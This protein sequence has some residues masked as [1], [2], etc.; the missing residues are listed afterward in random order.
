MCA[1]AM[2]AAPRGAGVADVSLAI[3]VDALT[4]VLAEVPAAA[5]R[6]LAAAN[7]SAANA[8]TS[9]HRSTP[10]LGHKPAGPRPVVP[11]MSSAPLAPAPAAA[12]KPSEGALDAE[13]LSPNP[14]EA[15]MDP[16]AADRVAVL[17]APAP[18]P[19]LPDTSDDTPPAPEGD[20]LLEEEGVLTGI[21]ASSPNSTRC[22]ANRGSENEWSGTDASKSDSIS[23]ASVTDR[24]TSTQGQPFSDHDSWSRDHT[25]KSHATLTRTLIL[26]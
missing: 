12:G 14:V 11:E 9:S 21:S 5:L 2:A 17:S 19:S 8:S 23:V 1:P 16:R 25:V 10:S 15:D 6:E 20:G 13:S 18:V 22:R 3:A 26:S 24:F 4:G 7:R